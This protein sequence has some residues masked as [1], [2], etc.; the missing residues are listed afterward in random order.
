[1]TIRYG[2]KMCPGTRVQPP[3]MLEGSPHNFAFDRTRAD[4]ICVYCRT[5]AC[6]RQ[7]EWREKNKAKKKAAR[8]KYYARTG[9]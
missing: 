2:M 6:F 5:C 8:K 3:H 7:K 9:K 4:Y 1:M